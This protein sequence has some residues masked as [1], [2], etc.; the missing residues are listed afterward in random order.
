VRARA[1]AKA[2]AR[3]TGVTHAQAERETFKRDKIVARDGHPMMCEC[4]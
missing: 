4:T 1:R 3:L 2:R